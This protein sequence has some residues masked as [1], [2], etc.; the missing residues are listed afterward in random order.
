MLLAR[1][2]DSN[3]RPGFGRV[4]DDTVFPQL[5]DIFGKHIDNGDPLAL[6]HC[7]W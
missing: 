3:G 5:G 6:N 4:V 7:V 1:Y 2:V